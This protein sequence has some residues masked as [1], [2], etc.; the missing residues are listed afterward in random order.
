LIDSGFI[1][2]RHFTQTVSTLFSSEF[3]TEVSRESIGFGIFLER[4]CIDLILT[5]ELASRIEYLLTEDLVA[6]NYSSITPDDITTEEGD[7]SIGEC[8]TCFYIS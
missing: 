1:G 8:V 6:S 4:D 7:P 2:L 3:I 5:I